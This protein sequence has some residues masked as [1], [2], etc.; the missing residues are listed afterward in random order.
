V[1]RAIAVVSSPLL[2]ALG[3]AAF[4]WLPAL[5]ERDFV[6]IARVIVSPDFDYRFNFV[7]PAELIALLPRADTGRLNPAFPAT[8]GIVQAVLALVGLERVLA[9]RPRHA[10]PILYLAGAGAILTVLLLSFSQP[11][12]DTVSLLGYVQLPMRLRGLIALCIA[13]LV[14]IPL[15]Y[16][17]RR[18]QTIGTGAILAVLVLSALPLLYPRYARDVPSQAGLADLIAFE[19]RTG[20]IGTTSFGEYLPVWVRDIPVTS[21]LEAEYARGAIPNRFLVPQGVVLCGE[22]LGRIRQSV[23]VSS[24]VAWRAQVR[25][26]Y[27]PGWS[28]EIDG[29]PV[30]TKATD[31][32]GQIEFEVPSG[33]HT[34]TLAYTGTAVES[35]AD[36]L[37]LFSAILVLGVFVIA[38]LLRIKARTR[39][40]ARS[41]PDAP[42]ATPA[43]PPSTVLYTLIPLFLLGLALIGVKSLYADRVS[44][45]FVHHS[46][47]TRVEGV[48]HKLDVRLGQEM[49]LLGFDLNAEELERGDTLNAV[50]YW[51]ILPARQ[52]DYSTFVHLTALDGSVLAQ[53]DN[54]HPAN[55]PTTRWDLDAYGA[56]AHAFEIPLTLAP[57]EYELRA[58]A[59]VPSSNVRLTTPEGRDYVV[60][61]KI[62]VVR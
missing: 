24:P 49:E 60:L 62:R 27:F 20:A 15:L 25:A 19:T 48:G 56:D 41:T 54:L 50:L 12:W 21:P 42:R 47:G 23:C 29:A 32:D 51:R 57:G 52:A 28:V 4:F 2:A 7:R 58:G 18:W 55:L 33:Q 34:L 22:T 1:S 36:G 35:V 8:L 10:P 59:Y 26:F 40:S 38:V 43:A 61:S 45:P 30:A 31:G 17:T 9:S 37:S 46:D 44:N 16:L 11:V 53:K 13:P 5:F 3:L 14:G 6:Q 39:T